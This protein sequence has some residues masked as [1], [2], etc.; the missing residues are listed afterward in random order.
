MARGFVQLDAGPG[1]RGGER[2]G[3]AR[4][5]RTHHRDAQRHCHAQP[6]TLARGALNIAGVSSPTAWRKAIR[7]LLSC[8]NLKLA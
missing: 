8:W 7:R 4:Q 5:A 2:A 1:A 3:Q 6:R